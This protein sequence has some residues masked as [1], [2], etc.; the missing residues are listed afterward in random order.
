[1][2]HLIISFIL[3]LSFGVG[4][5]EASVSVKL[6]PAGSFVGKS[7]EVKGSVV[8]KGDEVEASNIVVTLTNITTGIKLRDEHT[9]KHL[10]VEKFPEAVLVSAKGKGG[11][12]DGIIRIRGIEKPV[13]GTY[14]V[15][16]G[17]LLAEFPIKFSDFG[18]TGIK[19]MGI[20]VD[21]NGR[22][23]VTVPVGAAPAAAATATAPA[24]GKTAAPVAKPAPKKK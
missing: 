17:K 19:Y 2:K 9:R 14:K 21:D 1:M 18:I 24:P 5:Q 20:G 7:S 12:G 4:A 16:G 3:I 6:K 11:K 8:Q 22:I 15:E 23:N 13:S 10:E